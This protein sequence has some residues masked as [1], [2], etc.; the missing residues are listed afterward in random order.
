MPKLNL[1]RSIEIERSPEAVYEVL[2]DLSKWRPWNPWLVTEPSAEVTVAPDYKSYSWKGKITGAGE[3]KITAERPPTSLD[4]DL[5]FLEPFKS[6]AKVHFQLAPRGEGTH[7]FWSLDS[8]L[9]FFLFFM[10]KVMTALLSM[11]YQ[12]G[13]NMLK[14]YTE[15]GAVPS[16]LEQQGP[17]AYPGCQYVGLTT[18]CAIDDLGPRMAADFDKLRRWKDTGGAVASDEAFSVYHTWDLAGGR[19][20]YTSGY[21]VSA[22]AQGLPDGFVTGEIPKLSTFVIEHVGPYRHLANAWSVGMQLARNRTFRQSKSYPPFEIYSTPPG[23]VPENQQ[24]VAV[25]FPAR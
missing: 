6:T 13:L 20:K 21:P 23:T 14:D 24:R 19:V 11:D 16:R 2:S 18:E 7:V 17:S 5:V 4:L 3:M 15:T 12:R 25:H 1:Q 22:P 8:S 10:K 9:P